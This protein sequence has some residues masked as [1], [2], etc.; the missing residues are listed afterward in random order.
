[1]GALASDR[2]RV[3]AFLK[4]IDVLERCIERAL[5]AAAAAAL[6]DPVDAL[7]R[8]VRNDPQSATGFASRAR[9]PSRR[10]ACTR[11]C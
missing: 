9:R 3:E 11:R 1:V 7:T 5:N 2:A 10:K 4:D 8:T 6:L